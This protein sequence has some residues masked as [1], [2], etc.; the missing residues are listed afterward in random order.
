MLAPVLVTAP[1]LSP[2]TL[3]EAKRHC[4]IEADDTFHDDDVSGFI[5]AATAHLDG[6]AG[7]LNRALVTQTWRQDFASFTFG[8]L[9]LPVFPVASISEITYFDVSG[10][11]QT[12]ATS[13]YELR[14]DELG[15][16]VALKP[17]QEFP[18]TYPRADAVSVTFVAGDAVANVPQ[19]LKQAVLL[20]VGHYFANREAVAVGTIATNLPLAFDALI[21]PYRRVSI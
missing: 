18:G 7:I 11:E 12:L 9:S 15:S 16:Y 2:V 5:L 14:T 8:R 10:A 20:L 17:G 21:A 13:I 1:A 3:A 4:R 19:P 6:P